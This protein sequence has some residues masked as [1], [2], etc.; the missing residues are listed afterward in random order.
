MELGDKETVA[1]Y[2]HS[3]KR[4]MLSARNT[5]LYAYGHT[6]RVWYTKLYHTCMVHTI[7]TWYVPYAYG[8]KYAYGTEHYYRGV[9]NAAKSCTRLCNLCNFTKITPGLHPDYTGTIMFVIFTN[10]QLSLR[11]ATRSRN[12]LLKITDLY[13][14]YRLQR[15]YRP[16]VRDYSHVVDPSIIIYGYGSTCGY[17]P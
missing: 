10:I 1:T 15:D 11:N 16:S 5:S 12:R 14:G 13:Q 17:R 4:D 8:I 7:R 3:S 6:V 2:M 9:R